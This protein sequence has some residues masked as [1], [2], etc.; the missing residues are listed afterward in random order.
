MPRFVE[1]CIVGLPLPP[2]SGGGSELSISTIVPTSG[3]VVFM[4]SILP[5]MAE[6]PYLTG[7]LDGLPAR[8]NNSDI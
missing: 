8:D 2:P 5:E 6:K 1:G 4:S 7:I 3:S